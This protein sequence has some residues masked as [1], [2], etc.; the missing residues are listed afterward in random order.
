MTGGA[1]LGGY[2]ESEFARWYRLGQGGGRDGHGRSSSYAFLMARSRVSIHSSEDR[3]FCYYCSRAEFC[4]V[5]GKEGRGRKMNALTLDQQRDVEQRF[6]TLAARWIEIT[7]FRSNTRVLRSDPAYQELIALGKAIVPLIMA[8]LEREPRAC[9]FTVLTGLTAENPVPASAS[10][11]IDEM[12][13][14]WLDWGREHG[15]GV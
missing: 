7:R 15:C 10:G 12:A 9:W 11:R 3:E 8:E 14:A 6:Q 2:C 1:I 13:K 4:L 5:L